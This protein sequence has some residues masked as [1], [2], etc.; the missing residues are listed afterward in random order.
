MYEGEEKVLNKKKILSVVLLGT[1]LCFFCSCKGR[2]SRTALE[3]TIS[4]ETALLAQ[5]AEPLEKPAAELIF[6]KD[7]EAFGIL[8]GETETF[9]FLE[10]TE[11]DLGREE[12]SIPLPLAKELQEFVYK[13]DWEALEEKYGIQQFGWNK[14]SYEGEQY[15]AVLLS[16]NEEYDGGIRVWRDETGDMKDRMQ[17]IQICNILTGM[18]QVVCYENASYPY[19]EE[20]TTYIDDYMFNLLYWTRQGYDSVN[21]GRVY[22]GVEEA[23]PVSRWEQV[24]CIQLA[25]RDDF[26]EIDYDNDGEKEVLIRCT[27]EHFR[28]G[29]KVRRVN[30]HDDRCPDTIDL[31][32][33]ELKQLLVP[34]DG[35]LQQLWF[36]EIGGEIVTFCL[37]EMSWKDDL[38]LT[39]CVIREGEETKYLSSTAVRFTFETGV[40]SGNS[41]FSDVVWSREEENRKETEGVLSAKQIASYQE[42]RQIIKEG[43]IISNFDEELLEEVREALLTGYMQNDTDVLSKFCEKYEASAQ[44]ISLK[45]FEELLGEEFDNLSCGRNG[46]CEFDK[47]Y[48][49]DLDGD[50]TKEL[51]VCGQIYGGI[52]DR[53]FSVWEKAEDGSYVIGTD[54]YFSGGFYSFNSEACSLILYDGAYYLVQAGDW[55]EWISSLNILQLKTADSYERCYMYL[56]DNGYRTFQVYGKEE[57]PAVSGYLKENLEAILNIPL[58]CDP[59]LF[60]GD[61]QTALSDKERKQ[62]QAAFY[63]DIPEETGVF[64]IDMNGDGISEYVIK[65][66]FS[67]DNITCEYEMQPCFFCTEEGHIRTLKPEFAEYEPVNT[68]RTN[69]NLIQLWSKEIDDTVYLFR[70]FCQSRSGDC[71]VEASHVNG[72]KI[73]TDGIWYLLNDMCL[74]TENF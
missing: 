36:E 70:I 44:E 64:R 63:S 7:E 38:L 74:K 28:D 51:A 26:I 8:F 24:S 52:S 35:V 1:V 53:F 72:D 48:E 45:E 50:G 65:D 14:F 33:K 31:E 9:G 43:E 18:E 68:F 11:A 60:T 2:G 32:A 55:D 69:F 13:K 41:L 5:T 15:D 39:A 23:L 58:A 62:I 54:Y 12:G 61:E 73:E 34:E 16:A 42:K 49:I 59:V 37:Y 67:Y 57:L 17:G 30:F 10:L 40:L 66:C 29:M 3:K 27:D 21:Y 6:P 71:I 20:L 25:S 22:T 46:S 56:A 19:G 47:C 4:E